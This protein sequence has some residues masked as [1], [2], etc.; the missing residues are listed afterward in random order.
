MMKT[1]SKQTQ[2]LLRNHHSYIIIVLHRRRKLLIIGFM[3]NENDRFGKHK[4]TIFSLFVVTIICVFNFV[5]RGAEIDAR[6][7]FQ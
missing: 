5:M 3:F 6:T 1:E 2:I 4:W 7:S